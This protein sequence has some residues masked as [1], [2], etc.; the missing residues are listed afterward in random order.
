MERR[1]P[2]RFPIARGRGHGSR[3]L[4][5]GCASPATP[6]GFA[7]LRGCRRSA[8]LT[9]SGAKSDCAADPAPNTKNT[10]D[11]ARLP[12]ASPHPNQSAG[13]CLPTLQRKEVSE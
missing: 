13:V 6:G 5:S 12:S 2:P 7:S 4:V 9:F 10:G 3:K 1:E 11:D 8:P